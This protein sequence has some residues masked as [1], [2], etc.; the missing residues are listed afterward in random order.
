MDQFLSGGNNPD[1]PRRPH[2]LDDL[3]QAVLLD[4]VRRAV[5]SQQSYPV[6]ELGR[7]ESLRQRIEARAYFLW[8][9]RTGSAWWDPT[10]NWFQ[11]R[12]VECEDTDAP[13]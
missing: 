12:Q 8:E 13:G 4:Q 9:N 3:V 6:D 7:A 1:L 2:L 11:A 5:S 10:A